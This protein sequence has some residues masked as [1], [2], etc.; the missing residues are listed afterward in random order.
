MRAPALMILVAACAPE[1]LEAPF[2]GPDEA[3]RLLPEGQAELRF[4]ADF[5]ESQAGGPLLAG[6]AVHVVFDEARLPQCRGWKYGQPAWAVTAFWRIDGGD[7]HTGAV[8]MPSGPADLWI[9][10]D[11]PGTLELWF[12]NNDAFGCIAWDSD[13]GA[14]YRFDVVSARPEPGW[15]G[16]ASTAITRQTCG[17][18]FCDAD[19]LPLDQGFVYDTWARQ[20][21]LVAEASFRAWVPGV[22]D[23]DDTS[24]VWER[25]DARVHWSTHADLSDAD[26]DYASIHDFVGNDVRYAYRL[27]DLDP[28]GGSTVTDPADCPDAPLRLTADGQYVEADLYL[29]FSV[30]DAELRPAPGAAWHGT[31][32]D[33]AGLYAV[34]L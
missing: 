29:W 2:T 21:A 4:D 5:T 9:D 31:F 15:M 14:N 11:A 3:R 26:W 12:A 10:L 33:Y 18:T 16:A 27:R 24:Q 32:Q 17:G 13:Y 22:T 8:V 30:N 20:R 19:L 7:V 1:R 28:L 6:T 23:A 25:L 34:C